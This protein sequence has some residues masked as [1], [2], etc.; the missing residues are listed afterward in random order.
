M[1]HDGGDQAGL[2]LHDDDILVL[3]FLQIAN[4]P[5]IVS[6]HVQALGIFSLFIL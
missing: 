5:S 2:H 6:V 1:V 4:H 3:V